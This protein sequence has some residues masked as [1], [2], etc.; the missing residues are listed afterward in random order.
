MVGSG[1]GDANLGAKVFFVWDL[2]LEQVDRMLEETTP[3]TS[4]NWVLHSTFATDMGLI[5]KEAQQLQGNVEY[6]EDTV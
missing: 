4:A 6:A 2:S 5:K 3:C 1:P